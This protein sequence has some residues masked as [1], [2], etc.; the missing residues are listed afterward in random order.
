MIISLLTIAY[1]ERCGE[2][3]ATDLW[4]TTIYHA[5]AEVAV[6]DALKEDK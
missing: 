5:N 3:I 6:K 1:I 4:N 2:M